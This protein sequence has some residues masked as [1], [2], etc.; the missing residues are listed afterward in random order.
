MTYKFKEIKILILKKIPH[1]EKNCYLQCISSKGEHI[2]IFLKNGLTSKKFCILE[3]GNTFSIDTFHKNEKIYL[4]KF[5][6][7]KYR[8][9]LKNYQS[10]KTLATT[11]NLTNKIFQN[12]EFSPKIYSFVSAT[13]H[14]EFIDNQNYLIYFLINILFIEGFIDFKSNKNQ[15]LNKL[16]FYASQ[17]KHENFKKIQIAFQLEKDIKNFINQILEDNF[18]LPSIQRLLQQ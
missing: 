18:N 12:K 14:S 11:L 3:P 10:H 15:N 8:P 16:I 5:E 1:L 6:L 13:I 7:I 2:K 4:N 9:E 17:T